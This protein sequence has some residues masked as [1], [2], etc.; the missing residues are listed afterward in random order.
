MLQ[1]PEDMGLIAVAAR[2]TKGKGQSLVH[3]TVPLRPY[4]FR[5]KFVAPK[6]VLIFF[7][8]L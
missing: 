6:S 2:Q 5:F 1:L 8:I 3:Y 7:P 4:G